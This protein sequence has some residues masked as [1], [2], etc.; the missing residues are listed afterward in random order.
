MTEH[1]T[2]FDDLET[3]P[4][5]GCLSIRGTLRCPECGLFHQSVAD[6]PE[7]EIPPEP[8]PMEMRDIDTSLY[9]LDPR[10]P[11]NVP[12]EEEE[13]EDP[14]VGW[15]Q[16]STD[17]SFDERDDVARLTREVDEDS[18]FRKKVLSGD[19]DDD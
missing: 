7:P 2:D 3:C 11:L 1:L 14:T 5:C 9:S 18:D 15:D 4:D 16:P 19:D 6:L 12:E 13:L 10:A 8:V 17:F